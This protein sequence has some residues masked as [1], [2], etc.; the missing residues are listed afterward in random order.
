M[1]S[2]IKNRQEIIDCAQSSDL[3]AYR[4]Q[5][6]VLFGSRAKG[7]HKA[8]SD[9]DLAFLVDNPD[10]DGVTS[11]REYWANNP[12][13]NYED[14]NACV[15]PSSYFEAHMYDFGQLSH[16]IARYGEA[17]LGAW[18]INKEKLDKMTSTR[19]DDWDGN[20]RQ[21]YAYIEDFFSYVRRFKKAKE[22]WPLPS[23][24]NGM[25]MASQ[26]AAEHLV[27]GIAVRRYIE[28]RKIHDIAGL[29]EDMLRQ[30]PPDVNKSLWAIFTN[31]LKILDGPAR[32]DN[33]VA[34]ALT[35]PSVETVER[36][37]DRIGNTLTLFADEVISAL[38][39]PDNP[40]GMGLSAHSIGEKDHREGLLSHAQLQLLYLR[41]FCTDHQEIF[42]MPNMEKGM[43]SASSGIE[44]VLTV[45][46]QLVRMKEPFDMTL[47]KCI[48]AEKVLRQTGDG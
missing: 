16:Q 47:E 24:G 9:W 29:A 41:K 14:V 43:S 21:S 33:Q 1:L 26:R 2:T 17:L 6:I 38:E 20:L 27:K 15:L 19:P 11:L 10:V 7:T 37:Y 34:Y 22:Y 32:Q 25:V 39:I 18:N 8:D 46:E 44:G 28:P 4:V 36:A 40:A 45:P 35:A 42:L 31:R 5:S 23:I 30:K 3:A 12:F 13:R 48:E